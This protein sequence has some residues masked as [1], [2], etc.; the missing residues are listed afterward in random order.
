MV[1]ALVALFVAMGGTTFAVTKLPRRSVGSAELK[2]GAVRKENLATGAVTA[3]KLAKG[4]VSKA[5]AGPGSTGA[6]PIVHEVIPSDGVAYALKAGY[7]DKAG[8]A[9]RAK[10]ADRATLADSATSATS[11]TSAGSAG[12]AANADTLDGRDSSYF[13]SR[14]T[15]VN[16]PRSEFGPGQTSDL[17]IGPFKFTERCRINPAGVGSADVLISTT[18]NHRHSTA[19][20]SRPISLSRR[21]SPSAGSHTWRVRRARLRSRPRTTVRRSCRTEAR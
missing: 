4:L 16:I 3:A 13:L 9:D 10:L 8:K 21:A 17:M 15:F 6:P 2:R 12:T 11:A 1:V 18:Q 19:T 5:P 7:A 20:R 14:S